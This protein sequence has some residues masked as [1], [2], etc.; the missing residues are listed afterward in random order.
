MS[1]IPVLIFDRFDQEE[2]L[3]LKTNE[4]FKL[5][6]GKDSFSKEDLAEAKAIIIRSTTKITKDFLEKMPMLSLVV[7][8]TSG[9]DHLDLEAL[10]EKNI[11]SYFTP[12]ANIA[13]AS[14]LCFSLIK[15]LSKN[16]L[17]GQKMLR[18][19]AWKREQILGS[20]LEGKTLGIVGF[21]RIGSRVNQL[22]KAY[23]MKTIAFDPYLNP[24]DF[25]EQTEL[26][27]LEELLRISDIISLHVPYSKFTK[28]MFRR[29]Q[30]ESMQEHALLINCSRGNVISEEELLTALDE[31]KFAGA[32]LDVFEREPL[33]PE[34]RIANHPKILC[35][36]HLGGA[37]K[38]SQKKA[39]IRAVELLTEVLLKEKTPSNGKLPP[40]APWF[41]DI[42]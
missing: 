6:K 35:S 5:K 25:K 19:G 22:A 20:E 29:N 33:D 30:F 11:L 18:S 34:G 13:S 2:Y 27:G 4:N 39:A 17:A 28:R 7:T 3:N 37:T 31:G 15:N 24:D 26:L 23:G 9:F 12:E 38:E 16:F 36:P 32:A 41:Q 8:T 21:G 10:K 42:F 14:E 40:E 1:K